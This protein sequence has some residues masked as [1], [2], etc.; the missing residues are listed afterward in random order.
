MMLTK[1]GGMVGYGAIG[2]YVPLYEIIKTV[3]TVVPFFVFI[4]SPSICF[5]K[6]SDA[7]GSPPS[8]LPK[9][10]RHALTTSLPRLRSRKLEAVTRSAVGA[11]GAH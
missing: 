4:Y 3:E 2:M 11:A 1:C 8:D 5:S 10:P 7:S 6:Y 9:L